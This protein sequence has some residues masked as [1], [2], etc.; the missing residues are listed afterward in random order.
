MDSEGA[1]FA[2]PAVHTDSAAVYLGDV[3]DNGETQAG[4]PHFATPVPVHPVE[5]LEQAWKMLRCDAPPFIN[6]RYRNFLFSGRN[7]DTERPWKGNCT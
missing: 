5:S 3:F 2:D 1:A 4:A 6:H 7:I